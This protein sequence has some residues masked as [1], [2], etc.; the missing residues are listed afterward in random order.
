MKLCFIAGADSIHSKKW[1]EY[2]SE[3]G[4]DVHWLS[5]TPNIFGEIKNVKLYLL[6]RCFLKP[7]ELLLNVLTVRKLVKKICPDIL[8]AHYVGVN[9]ILAGL[10]GFHPFVLT[11][12]GSDILI[13]SKSGIIRPLIK[14]ALRGADLITCD[15]EHM[16]KAMIGLGVDAEKIR[17]IHFGIDIQRFSPGSKD[18]KL[19]TELGIENEL[20]II[21]LRSLE[22]VYNIETLVKAVP[23]VL[24]EFPKTKFV[25]AG[26]GSEEKKLKDMVRSL[27]I[28]ENVRFT[29]FVSN[30]DLPRYFKTA[31][32]YVSTSL[33]DAGIAA[34]T[35]EA[36]SCG[37]PVII[38]NTGENEKWVEDGKGGYLIPIKNP[39]VLAE[40]I[41]DLL[42]NENLRKEFGRVNRRI[43]E[44]RNNHSIEM[45]KIENLYEEIIE[46]NKKTNG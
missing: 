14:F 46:K 39:E 18:E 21:S 17:I 12:W 19:K 30:D 36:M 41:I 16:K 13:T 42:K 6:K 11:A 5:L 25:I 28:E 8:H 32:I 24:K 35:A 44:E 9:G 34:S 10:T 20:T 26:Q 3:K 31:D 1:I 4:N 15:A 45:D 2:F 23:L 33:S 7:L 38:T 37:L 27:K 40:K 22:P 29:G 43:I